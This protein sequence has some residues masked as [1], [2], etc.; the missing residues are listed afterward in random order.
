MNILQKLTSVNTISFKVKIKHEKYL[1]DN[2]YF[3]MPCQ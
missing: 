3:F 1:T 2:Y